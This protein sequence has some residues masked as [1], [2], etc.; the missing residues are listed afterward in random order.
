MIRLNFML[1]YLLT[2]PS[3]NVVNVFCELLD[4]ML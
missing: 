3:S 4:K 1:A 2:T